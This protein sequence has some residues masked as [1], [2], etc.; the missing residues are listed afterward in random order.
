VTGRKSTASNIPAA[1]G[2]IAHI[3]GPAL[4]LFLFAL[5]ILVLYHTLRQYHVQDIAH[6]LSEIPPHRIWLSIGLTGLNYL[7]LSGYDA[8]AFRYIRNPLPYRK[9][10]LASFI[11]YAF[12]TNTGTLSVITS[13]GVRYRLY[14]G[15]GLSAVDVAKVIAFCSVSFWLGFLTLGGVA[16]LVEPI[17][18]PKALHLP[19]DSVRF[20]GTVFVLLVATYLVW[21]AIRRGPLKIHGWGFAVPSLGL[22]I[23]QIAVSVTD[24]VVAGS[25]LYALLPPVAMLSFPGF[26]GMFLLAQAVGLVSNVPGGLGVFE[27]VMLLLLA[28]FVP[29]SSVVGPLLVYRGVYYLLPLG[30]ASALMGAYEVVQGREGLERLATAFGRVVSS[31]VPQV[32]AFTTFL[33]GAILLFSGATPSVGERLE[34]LRTIVPLPVLEVSHF[35]GSLAGMGLLVLAF[36]LWRR[37]DAAYFLS[38]ALLA[39]GGIFSLLKGLDYEEAMVLLFMLAVLLP[40]QREFYRRASLVAEPLSPGWIAAVSIVV[41]GSVWLGFFFYRHLDYSNELWWRFALEANA[42]RF[43]RAT[44]GTVALALFFA[45]AKLLHPSPPPLTPP[46]PWDLERV[47]SIAQHS[48]RTSSYLALLG[49]KSF[50]FSDGNNAFI[51]YAVEGRSW[52]AL[53]DPIGPLEEIPDLLWRFRGL[54]DRYGG[55]P[56]FYEV[57]QENLP[58]YLDLGLSPLKIGEDGRVALDTFSLEGS[59]RKG[60][61]HSHNRAQKEGYSFQVIPREE[62]SFLLPEFKRI[63]DDW[64]TKKHTREKGFSLGFFDEDY[65][66]RF[67]A[68]VIRREG[69]VLAFAN[70]LPGSEKEELSID[71]MRYMPDA[72]GGVMDYLFIELMLWG[73]AQGYHWFSLGMAPLSGLED[74]ELAPLW[75]RI[76]AFLF[77]HGEHFYNFQ[78]LRDYKD[79]F[80][81]VWEPRYLVSPGGFALPRIFMDLAS[82]VSRGLKGVVAK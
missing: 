65:L 31:L 41:L 18:L 14:A 3:V 69:H 7:V 55:W 27:T 16:F 21:S 70:V 36:G 59:S 35:L 46:S 75:N 19:F 64:L 29:A 24:W 49:D 45:A 82:L 11:G 9:I 80:E 72:S 12:A 78:G 48:L 13:S 20:V 54:S 62:V 52:V 39:A 5:A 30:I 43:L 51:M 79:K 25:V 66:S 77:R 33:G 10:A 4:A 60:L 53:G 57:G 67:P 44:L 26:L 42:P 32:L 40:C 76:G 58:L 8:L 37:L 6:S 28:P 81:P 1:S 47:A 23:A 68:A 22:S 63:S 34:W 56:V 74:R 2:R 50:L 61:R 38:A 15:W 73:K 71:L 17:P